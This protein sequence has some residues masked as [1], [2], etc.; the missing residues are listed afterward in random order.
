MTGRST[1]KRATSRRR[2]ASKAAPRAKS[3]AKKSSG[4]RTYKKSAAKAKA[5]PSVLRAD[6]GRGRKPLRDC[7]AH[8]LKDYFKTL[9]GHDVSDLYDFVIAEVEAPL[10][11][12]VLR[13]TNGNQTRAAEMLGIN[14]GTL[15]KKL[16][17]YHLDA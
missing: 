16:K 14:R 11:D 13:H 1:K 12:A 15:R 8:A 5:R 3:Q 10:L 2:S 4:S 6:D 7:T 17:Q 9:N